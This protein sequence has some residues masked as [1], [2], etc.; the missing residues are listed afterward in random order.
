MSSMHLIERLLGSK[1]AVLVGALALGLTMSACS[2]VSQDDM[3]SQLAQIRDE[4]TQGDQQNA[5]EID[6]VAQSVGDLSGR[7]ADLE[8][9]LQGLEQDFN[10]TVERLENALRF[11]T[12]IHFAYDEAEIRTQDEQYLDRFSSVVG[13]YYPDATVTVEG[14]TDPA[15]SA[16]Y[17]LQLGQR[18]ADS[19]RDYL[20]E[21][22]GLTGD[23]IRSV[24]YGE[25][26]S[27][28]INPD[29]QGPGNDGLNNR[30]VVLVVDHV[31]GTRGSGMPPS[32]SSGS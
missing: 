24:S 16:E 13:E 5:Q 27:R 7:V 29:A 15:G 14:F 26:T 6:E 32:S 18:R 30:R 17:N 20:V 2:Y 28:L 1:G 11:S 3:D 19:V 4:M 21:S 12:P 23:R 25:D 9:E 10:T 22:G 31:P 8:Q